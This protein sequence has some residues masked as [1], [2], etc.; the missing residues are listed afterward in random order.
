MIL[1]YV[2][3]MA[4]GR[5]GGDGTGMGGGRNIDIASISAG[6]LSLKFILGGISALAGLILL[7]T[8]K[9]NRNIRTLLM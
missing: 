7:R 1:I 3:V 8:T 6:L 5:G 9:I 4:E 2:P